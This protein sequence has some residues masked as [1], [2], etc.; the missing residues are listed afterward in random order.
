VC[1]P[2][3][4]A[5]YG[6]ATLALHL[7]N[8]QA[9]NAAVGQAGAQDG[10]DPVERVPGAAPVAGRLL[11]RPPAYFVD[12]VAAELDDMKGVDDRGRVFEA[13]IDG[14]LVPVEGVQ[15][16]DLDPGSERLTSGGEPVPAPTPT[17]KY[18]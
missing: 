18:G 8:E 1:L 9:V 12:G 17:L 2:I 13:V 6:G 4:P 7:G 16:G 15:C 11:L 3:R 10:P 5:A 14:V